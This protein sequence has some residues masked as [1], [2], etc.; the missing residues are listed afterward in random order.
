MLSPFGTLLSQD[1]GN[2]G[3]HIL[4]TLQ[5]LPL[6]QQCDLVCRTAPAVLLP[7]QPGPSATKAKSDTFK[8]I[9]DGVTVGRHAH[10]GRSAAPSPGALGDLWRRGVLEQRRPTLIVTVGDGVTGDQKAGDALIG[11]RRY[12]TPRTLL[13]GR[14]RQLL[15]SNI[16]PVET[17][18][19]PRNPRCLRHAALVRLS[20]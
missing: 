17:P 18:R 2:R 10:L 4:D 11:H 3:R 12:A 8:L 16:R 15:S 7:F 6:E 1:L 19:R 5:G 9:C 20:S 14:V 13:M